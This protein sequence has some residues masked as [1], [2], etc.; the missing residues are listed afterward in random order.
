MLDEQEQLNLI[1]S[2]ERDVNK[3][4]ARAKQ[5]IGPLGVALVIMYC[6][7]A[8]W[9]LLDFGSIRHHTELHDVLRPM[10]VAIGELTGAASVIAGSLAVVHLNPMHP[11]RSHTYLQ[12]A[13]SITV[14]QALLWTA[15]IVKLLRIRNYVLVRRE[16][17][18][19][20]PTTRG[21]HIPVPDAKIALRTQGNAYFVRS[22]ALLKL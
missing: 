21:A 10:A 3:A 5:L 14:F 4:T 2:L 17:L 15:T 22:V 20:V 6:Y 1:E 7:F 8:A 18:A 13:V 16:G 19:L 12:A 11:A 9:A